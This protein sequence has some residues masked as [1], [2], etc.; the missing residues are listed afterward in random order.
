MEGKLQPIIHII[1][2]TLF[3]TEDFD[4]IINGYCKDRI[5]YRFVERGDY[6]VIRTEDSKAI[7]PLEFSGMVES[8]MVVEMSIVLRQ[9]NIARNIC[10]R[11]GH[12][13]RNVTSQWSW[14]E[15]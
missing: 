9:R 1:L 14:M 13:N 15:W 8:G 3:D 7:N 12:S 2:L 10:P 6:K 4:Y 5:G 11:C